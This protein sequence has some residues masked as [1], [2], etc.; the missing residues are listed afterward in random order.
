MAATQ[1]ELNALNE[2]IRTGAKT[3]TFSTTG[4]TSRTVVYDDYD[5]LLRRRSDL[6]RE[7]GT[8]ATRLR[9]GRATYSRGL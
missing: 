2:A 5:K 1:T 4:G 7:L 8:G 9:R 6:E 3:V